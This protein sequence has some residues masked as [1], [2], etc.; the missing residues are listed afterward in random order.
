M[1]YQATHPNPDLRH[2]DT[3]HDPD[4][5]D[6]RRLAVRSDADGMRGLGVERG[7]RE[8][9]GDEHPAFP[10]QASEDGEG[11]PPSVLRACPGMEC[12]LR[13]RIPSGRRWRSRSK[14]FFLTPDPV[15]GEEPRAGDYVRSCQWE[16]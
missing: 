7:E 14:E 4:G 13:G 2:I 16:V 8:A 10:E 1:A 15:S 12:L 5:G 3:R 9:Q 6:V 11:R